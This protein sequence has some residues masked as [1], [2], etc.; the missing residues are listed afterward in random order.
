MADTETEICNL[1]LSD[2]G[3]KR[4]DD[5]D[6]DT[7]VQAILCRLHYPRTRDALLRSYDWRFASWRAT[8]TQDTNDPDFEWDNQFILPDDFLKL[9]SVYEEEGY[10]SKSRRHAI[11]GDRFLTNESD[12]N[13]RYIRKI[14]DVAEFEP[15]F[16]QLLILH[17][18]L[19]L[20][21][22]LT[23]DVK[24]KESIKS[25]IVLVM[26]KVVGVNDDETDTGGRSDWNLARH[27]GIGIQSQEERFW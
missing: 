1:S 17:L 9:K 3:A 6:D 24:L 10:N 27:G 4:L 21:M 23:Q 18:D 20:V 22:P 11:E 8:L 26:P 2:L 16:V 12:A 7:T 25:D 15:L 13:I 14:T 5:Y 19:K